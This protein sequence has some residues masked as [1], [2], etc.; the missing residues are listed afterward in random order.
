[1]HLRSDSKWMV[2]EPELTLCIN[3]RGDII[4]YTVGND[5]SCRDI[6]GENP[7]Y[8]PQ[9]KCFKLCAALG[10]A[11]L[12]P[13]EPPAPTTRIHFQIDRAGVAAF[14]G[15]TVYA[16]LHAREHDPAPSG[17]VA[18]AAAAKGQAYGRDRLSRDAEGPIAHGGRQ[19]GAEVSRA[20]ACNSPP[21]RP[22]RAL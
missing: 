10:P 18:G 4:G 19:A 5:L 12:I 11:I 3:S 21:T 7:L 8:L 22:P 15:E 6:E 17:G 20:S 2:P 14:E 16:Q 13:N 1:M 9:A